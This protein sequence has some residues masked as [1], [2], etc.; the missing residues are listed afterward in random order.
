MS[1]PEKAVGP[2]AKGEVA[3]VPG[4]LQ[5]TAPKPG[6]LKLVQNQVSNAQARHGKR[7][8]MDDV[9]LAKQA[10]LEEPQVPREENRGGAAVI[11]RQKPAHLLAG[12]VV[13]VLV[14]KFVPTSRVAVKAG[15]AVGLKIA[16]TKAVQNYLNK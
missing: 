14:L 16:A 2:P 15:M 6:L 10:L 5:E 9:L 7:T 12:L 13:F 8:V 11:L 4:P 1:T 3:Y